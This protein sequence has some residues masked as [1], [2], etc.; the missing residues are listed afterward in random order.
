MSF[1][2]C[3]GSL[4][5]PR[6]RM[7]SLVLALSFWE[8]GNHSNYYY[9]FWHSF[10]LQHAW[11][12]SKTNMLASGSHASLP[13]LV[14][15]LGSLWVHPSCLHILWYNSHNFY[16]LALY[17]SFFNF[18]V[19]VSTRWSLWMA[20]R[21]CGI[22]LFDLD[23]DEYENVRIYRSCWWGMKGKSTNLRTQWLHEII[24]RLFQLKDNSNKNGNLATSE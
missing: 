1:S 8:A 10:P 2:L 24:F 3:D 23:E 22:V 17:W 9:H 14:C 5:S 12:R 15:F 13:P 4:F 20:M 19:L 7:H 6:G 18:I 16:L 21:K 11:T